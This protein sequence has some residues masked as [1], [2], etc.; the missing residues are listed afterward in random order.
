MASQILIFAL[1]ALSLNLLLGYGGMVSLGHAA[2]IGVAGYTCI[3]LTVAGYNPLLAAIARARVL[4]RYAPALFGM[5]SLRAPGLGFLMITLALGQ[6]VWGIA[7]RANN[8]TGGDNG[9]RLPARPTP[10]G[11]DITQRAELLLFHAD[12]VRG[13]AVLHLALRRA[14]RSAPA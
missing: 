11:F 12:R 13:R 4:D 7:Y 2:Y 3:L 10:F 6:I 1:L 8:L 9:I 5:L 14:R